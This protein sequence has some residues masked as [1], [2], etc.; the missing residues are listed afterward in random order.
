MIQKEVWGRIDKIKESAEQGEFETKEEI[1]TE[2]DRAFEEAQS[3]VRGYYT[4]FRNTMKQR[5]KT[6]RNLSRISP[7]ALFQYA[8]EGI[9]DSAAIRVTL[10][11]T[12]TGTA[13]STGFTDGSGNP[14]SNY[15]AD[16]T[17]CVQVIDMDQNLNPAAVETV[18]RE[19]GDRMGS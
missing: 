9:A 2:T 13:G 18:S 11:F 8:S 14:V 1:L 17:I 12:D 5:S 4:N 15:N 16:A 7:T 3:K 10:S 6:A 19:L